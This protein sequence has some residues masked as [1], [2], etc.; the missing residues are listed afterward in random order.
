MLSPTTICVRT[1]DKSDV[2]NANLS[3]SKAVT[4]QQYQEFMFLRGMSIDNLPCS[5]VSYFC[6]TDTIPA[7]LTIADALQMRGAKEKELIDEDPALGSSSTPYT[8][9]YSTPTHPGSTQ[10]FVSNRGKTKVR[11]TNGKTNGSTVASAST[12]HV[13]HTVLSNRQAPAWSTHDASAQSVLDARPWS[14]WSDTAQPHPPAR[15]EPA[16]APPSHPPPRPPQNGRSQAGPYPV[17]S[18]NGHISSSSRPPA[19]HPRDDRMD[20]IPPPPPHLSP[21][22]SRSHHASHSPPHHAPRA[23]FAAREGSWPASPGR[24]SSAGPAPPSSGFPPGPGGSPFGPSQN[25][26]RT[27]Y[28]QQPPQRAAAP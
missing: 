24:H 3:L 4:T 8:S 28:S 25:P 26:G 11:L 19:T 2:Y 18:L 13:N 5:S 23:S 15:V 27:I 20:T 16:H 7:P 6:C 9:S 22:S 10:P 17:P 12:S 1:S 21:N 14:N